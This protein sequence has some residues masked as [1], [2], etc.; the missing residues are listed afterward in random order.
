MPMILTCYEKVQ[1]YKT[2]PSQ[3]YST[4]KVVYI[5]GDS[6]LKINYIF[7]PLVHYKTSCFVPVYP[8]FIEMQELKNYLIEKLMLLRQWYYS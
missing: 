7:K 8:K 5:S 4:D 1:S 2:E 6:V 3:S